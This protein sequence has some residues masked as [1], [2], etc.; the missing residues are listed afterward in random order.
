MRKHNSKNIISANVSG[1]V[2][3]TIL[4]TIDNAT[5]RAQTFF[6]DRLFPTTTV[7]EKHQRPLVCPTKEKVLNFCHSNKKLKKTISDEVFLG[8]QQ[9]KQ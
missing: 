9:A 1:K 4:I 2:L 7:S 6:K 3:S 8:D 5:R